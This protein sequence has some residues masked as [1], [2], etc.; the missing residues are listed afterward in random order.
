MGGGKGWLCGLFIGSELVI[1]GAERFPVLIG[2]IV[3]IALITD[4]KLG[5]LLCLFAIF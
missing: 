2:S 1:L 4:V 3:W 5:V